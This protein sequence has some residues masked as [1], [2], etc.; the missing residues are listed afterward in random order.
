MESGV[1]HVKS[2]Q[3][4]LLVGTDMATEKSRKEYGFITKYRV[5]AGGAGVYTQNEIKIKALEVQEIVVGNK[6][7]P[8]DDYLA[9]R[10]M[11]FVLEG[12]YN[13]APFAEIF[14]SFKSMG[15]SIFDLLLFISDRSDLY[16]QKVGE[17]LDLYGKCQR[18]ICLI[19]LRKRAF[20][21]TRLWNYM[22]KASLASMK[23]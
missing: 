5:M 17:I 22:K 19:H 10:L 16:T 6:D 2:Y 23:H 12:F 7:M 21:Q 18:A 20:N 1:V 11:D 4:M 8:F 14:E 15:Y 13:N 3:A 9:C